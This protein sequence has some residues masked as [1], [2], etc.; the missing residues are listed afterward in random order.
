MCAHR[1][2]CAVALTHNRLVNPPRWG[3]GSARAVLAL[4]V[5][6]AV[7]VGCY[8]LFGARS[9]PGG[10]APDRA[11]SQ[12]SLPPPAGPGTAEPTAREHTIAVAGASRTYRSYV[13]PGPPEHWPLLVVLHGRGQSWQTVTGQTGFLPLARQRQA[14]LVFPDGIGRSWNAG[15]GCCGLAGRQRLPD[16]A[17]VASVLVDALAH[18]PVD[19]SRVYLVGYSNGG[20]LA[21]RLSCAH[22]GLFAALATYGSAPLAACPA[23]T[24]PTPYLI[25]A[26]ERDPILP[27]NGAPRAHPPTPSIRVATGWLRAQDGCVGPPTEVS[28]GQLVQQDW[29]HCA[30][31]TEVRSVVYTAAGHGWPSSPSVAKLMWR[32]LVAH[33][34]PGVSASASETATSNP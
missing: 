11:A 15:G 23:G 26:G 30:G 19:S 27:F 7:G 24:P 34:L 13:P 28:T 22:P 18:L 8:G 3:R 25:A 16:V 17:F 14:V 9:T 29:M 5:A 32:F 20:K 6:V 31:G 1:D 12:D 33:R 4:A 10:S 21:Y 2:V